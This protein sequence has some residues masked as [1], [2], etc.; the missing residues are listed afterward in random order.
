MSSFNNWLSKI[1]I[2]L[3][4]VTPIQEDILLSKID[5]LKSE[6]SVNSI[7]E[8]VITKADPLNVYNNADT[9]GKIQAETIFIRM[10]FRVISL[11]AAK[12]WLV[13]KHEQKSFIVE[14]FTVFLLHCI[15]LFQSG[16]CCKFI[17]TLFI[18]IIFILGSHCKISNKAATVF[19][20]ES[21]KKNKE[22]NI[23]SIN[24]NILR[25]SS[26]QPIATFYWNYLLSLLT[27]SDPDIYS[28]FIIYPTS[29]KPWKNP[30]INLEI[31][32]T[33]CLIS[34]CDYLVNFCTKTINKNVINMF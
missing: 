11:V 3:L 21:L 5:Q 2:I 30:S 10:I 13:L 31:T 23:N 34:L 33:G 27:Y 1:Y 18:L 19:N 8:N 15:C 29:E 32:K 12:S 16:R 9:F 20:T 24:K 25:L 6:F 4:I 22:L 26:F 7:Y 17:K 28:S 14:Q